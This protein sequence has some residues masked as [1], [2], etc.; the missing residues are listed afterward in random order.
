MSNSDI[1]A[2]IEALPSDKLLHLVHIPDG[3]ISVQYVSTN[4]KTD[5]LKTLASQLR[6]A[7]EALENYADVCSKCLSLQDDHD[8][9]GEVDLMDEW[10]Q[11]ICGSPEYPARAVLD[12]LEKEK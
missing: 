6:E 10:G 2:K 9:N 5:D 7:K 3:R 4:I 8:K 12:R 11:M 1:E